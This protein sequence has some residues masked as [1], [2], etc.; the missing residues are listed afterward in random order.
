MDINHID[1]F[2]DAISLSLSFLT[3]VVCYLLWKEVKKD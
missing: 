2:I 3:G 1:L